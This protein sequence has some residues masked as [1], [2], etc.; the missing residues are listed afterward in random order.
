MEPR[1]PNVTVELV[2]R[3]GNAF[4]ILGRVRKALRD[5]GVPDDEIRRF[6]EEATQGDYAHLL[7]SVIRWVEVT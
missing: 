1:Y 3:D 6:T 4:A 7:Q 5:A 2:G